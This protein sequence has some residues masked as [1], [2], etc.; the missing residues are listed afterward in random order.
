MSTCALLFFGLMK[1]FE[2]L[3]LPVI[4]QNILKN[5]P[6][7]DIFLHT[8]GLDKSLLNECNKEIKSD[9]I[10]TTDAYLLTKH[11]TIESMESFYTKCEDFLEHS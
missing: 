4:K 6:H 5:N 10:N 9:K 7:C 2:D 8:Y 11:I 3:A 1:S